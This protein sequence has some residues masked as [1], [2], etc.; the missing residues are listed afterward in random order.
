[1][2]SSIR[3]EKPEVLIMNNKATQQ[4][5]LCGND[6]SSL[7]EEAVSLLQVMSFAQTVEECRSD[8]IL[9]EKDVV[10][11]LT[12]I[13]V[14]KFAS[15]CK[16]NEVEVDLSP[17]D[18]FTVCVIKGKEKKNVEQAAKRLQRLV[19]K[20]SLKL[21]LENV[22]FSPTA[23][24]GKHRQI[25]EIEKIHKHE[26]L[27]CYDEAKTTLYLVGEE[28]P[29]KATREHIEAMFGTK[30]KRGNSLRRGSRKLDTAEA[31]KHES[32][33][34]VPKKDWER[35]MKTI[36]A[37]PNRASEVISSSSSTSV[38][39]K[40]KKSYQHS[41]SNT[42][43][44]VLKYGITKLYVDAIVNSANSFLRHGAGVGRAI[45]N[46]AGYELV[47]ECDAHVRKYGPIPVTQVFMS[48]AGSLPCKKVLHAVGP[49]GTLQNDTTTGLHEVEQVLANC[50]AMAD[51]QAFGSIAFPPVGAG[52]SFK[53][54]S[55]S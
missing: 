3:K 2:I 52:M 33:T 25:D 5:V 31:K 10:E 38:F 34:K 1:M 44:H 49:S 30:R 51:Q 11:Y 54:T 4:L 20:Y 27:F 21:V 43:I 55:C 19:E 7:M 15:I 17:G 53:I 24:K 39:L 12:N 29:V 14:D 48:T 28:D 45:A 23:Y 47:R 26:V 46:A 8:D 36:G 40:D 50:L 9:V 22:L 6:A 37:T 42:V 32:A 13:D 18:D 35:L 41:Y 16:E